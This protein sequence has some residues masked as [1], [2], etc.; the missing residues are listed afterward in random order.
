MRHKQSVVVVNQMLRGNPT[1]SLH[2][3]AKNLAHVQ[4]VIH[5]SANIHQ[6][7]NAQYF[8]FA[9]VRI[10]FHFAGRNALRE[11]QKRTALPFDL[12]KCEMRGCV[13]SVVTDRGA[14][15]IGL[16]HQL[17][18]VNFKFGLRGLTHNNHRVAKLNKCFIFSG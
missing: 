2:K 10:K 12:V 1:H 4:R 16:A 8:N 13:M 9:G 5:G 14:I 15:E 6:H 17:R 18:E 11:V 3:S 7:V